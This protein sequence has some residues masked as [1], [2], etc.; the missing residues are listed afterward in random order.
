MKIL[1]LCL[2]LNYKNTPNELGGCENDAEFWGK[3]FADF[4]RRV[5]PASPAPILQFS[6]IES[7]V[8]TFFKQAQSL[9]KGDLCIFQYSGHGTQIRQ[10]DGTYKEALVLY[11]EKTRKYEL[12]YD[13]ELQEMLKPLSCTT[14]VILDSCFSGGMDKKVKSSWDNA[15][16]CRYMLAF[17]IPLA[18]HRDVRTKQTLA[19]NL[20]SVFYMAACKKEE[21]AADLGDMGAFSKACKSAFNAGKNTTLSVMK[22]AEAEIKRYQTPT[23]ISVGGRKWLKIS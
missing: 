8:T 18:F 16:R 10:T 2:G 5:A 15:A 3:H 20:S 21:T 12:L 4:S 14:L 11:H 17:D 22:Y 1:T 23:S 6:A 13:Y 7:D 19:Q 9:K